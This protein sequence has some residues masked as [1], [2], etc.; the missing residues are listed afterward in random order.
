MTSVLM[1]HAPF[2]A[3]EITQSG[4]PPPGR[5]FRRHLSKTT[6]A[7]PGPE[8]RYFRKT[9]SLQW[10]PSAASLEL[11]PVADDGAVIYLNGTEV[12]RANVPPTN[13]VTD[14]NFTPAAVSISNAALLNGS[15]VLSA[16]VHQFR[17]ETMT[18]SFGAELVITSVP[19]S[20]SRTVRHRWSSTR[21]PPPATEDSSSRSAILRGSRGYVGMDSQDEHRRNGHSSFTERAQ[22]EAMRAFPER[23]LGFIPANWHAPLPH[24]ARR[25]GITRLREI[26]N[27]LTG[28]LPDG[29]WGFPSS[30]PRRNECRCRERCRGR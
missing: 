28:F 2:P 8:P 24:S 21:L 3:S 9:F 17:V 4:T 18:C 29:R 30:Q 15:N 20:L 14:A 12:W 19:R 27:R 10:H 25:F 23:R 5:C 7:T 26:K 13:E 1:G 22:R 6:T 11:W 16:E